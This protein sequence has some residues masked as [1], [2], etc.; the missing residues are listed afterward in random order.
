MQQMARYLKI[1]IILWIHNVE[2]PRLKLENL[3][4]RLVFL[5]KS[6]PK[7]RKQENLGRENSE[8]SQEVII[9]HECKIRLNWSIKRGISECKKCPN[10][11][12]KSNLTSKQYS[13]REG[14]Y[15]IQ[16]VKE[17]SSED[18]IDR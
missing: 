6:N 2:K 11:V 3:V 7:C 4:L 18:Y 12:F 1:L 14:S 16:I 17:I 13:Q 9:L 5:E 15:F 10:I 8:F